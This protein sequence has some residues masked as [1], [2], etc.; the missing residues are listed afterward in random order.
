[1]KLRFQ[2]VALVGKYQAPTSAGMSDSSRDALDGIA[3]FLANEGCEV[4]LEADTAANTGFTDY[5]ALSVERIGLD[6]DLCLVVGGD[7]TMLG[8][9]RQLAQYRTPLIGINQGRLGFIT[10]IPLGEYPTVLKPMLR[11]EYEEDLRPLMRARVMRQGQCV[12]EALAMNDVVVNRGSTS[13]M[14]ELRVE[15]G[16]HFVSNQRADGLIIASP[17]G[18]TAYA[19][20]AGGPMLHPTIPGWVL[21]P[22]A[23]HTLSNRPIV[24]S[25]SMEVAVEVVSGRDV[26]AN[27]D[28]QSLA[29]LQH[30]DRILVQRSDY[31]ARFLHPRG[32][33]YFATLR[34]KLRW[35]EGGY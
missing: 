25:D 35:N 5:P 14:V 28:M 8:V 7:G 12:F 10:D 1:M 3:R 2:R 19:L 18:S 23:P 9:G 24:L 30:G 15:V 32:W 21:A 29:S 34:K 22:I 6:C 26:S 11:G 16:G 20:S 17:T 4:A 31:R 13:G 33:N 27:F